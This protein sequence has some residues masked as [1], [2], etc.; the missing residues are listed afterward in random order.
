M[1]DNKIQLAYARKL[2]E[3]KDSCKVLAEKKVKIGGHQVIVA[4]VERVHTRHTF[5]K[6][7]ECS[8]ED[9]IMVRIGSKHQRFIIKSQTCPFCK[10]KSCGHTCGFQLMEEE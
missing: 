10:K 6:N 5:I 7:P 3:L 8:F 2:K 4:L 1:S 9:K